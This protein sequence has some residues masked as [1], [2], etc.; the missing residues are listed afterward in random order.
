MGDLNMPQ[1][2]RIGSYLVCFCANENDPL[3]PIHV[4]ISTGVLFS[5]AT[6]VWIT[7]AGK[8]IILCN[9]NSKI[10]KHVLGN[11][12]AIIEPRSEEV[13]EKWL[14]FFG[15][16]RYYCLGSCLT[17]KLNTWSLTLNPAGSEIE[18]F[19]WVMNYSKNTILLK[20]FLCLSEKGGLL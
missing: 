20:N 8:C 15:D 9:N 16:I 10:P 4:H 5:N 19:V 17:K 13:I 1:I 11:I 3:E 18:L 7:K 14:D 6:K 2:F 12:P